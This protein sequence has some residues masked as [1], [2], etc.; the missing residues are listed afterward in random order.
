MER[1]GDRGLSRRTLAIILGAL[2]VLAGVGGFRYASFLL[3]GTSTGSRALTAGAET[4][5]AVHVKG[6]VMEPG[7]YWLAADSRTADAIAAAGGPAEGADLDRINLAAPLTDGSQLAVPFASETAEE[8][9]DPAGGLININTAT[10][11]QLQTLDGIGEVKARAIIDYRESHG[12]FTSVE[13]LTRVEGIGSAT[14]EKIRDR[15]S[16][17]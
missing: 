13:Q 11:A 9:D 7:L 4:E 17:Y 5:I 10:S 15:I 2:L 1:P 3:Q 16:V 14:L 8:E 12:D 6:A